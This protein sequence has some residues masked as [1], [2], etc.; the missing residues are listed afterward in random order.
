MFVWVMAHLLAPSALW[1]SHLSEKS[2]AACSLQRSRVKGRICSA[3]AKGTL[4]L[5]CSVLVRYM[6]SIKIVCIEDR[7]IR[8]TLCMIVPVS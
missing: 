3:F 6:H 7:E 2:Q 8:S 4:L 5:L 1:S